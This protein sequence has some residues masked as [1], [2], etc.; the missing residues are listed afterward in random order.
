MSSIMAQKA[1]VECL[2]GDKEIMCSDIFWLIRGLT[3]GGFI[4]LWS[5][6]FW[7]FGRSVIL[8]HNVSFR[9]L[10]STFYISW[11]EINKNVQWFIEFIFLPTDGSICSILDCSRI[12]MQYQLGLVSIMFCSWCFVDIGTFCKLSKYIYFLCCIVLCKSFL[13]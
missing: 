2:K 4:I 1:L 9:F 5:I 3:S 13:F 10:Y 12:I 6:C 11:C 7:Y 8:Q